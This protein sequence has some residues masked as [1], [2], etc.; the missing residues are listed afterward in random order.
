MGFIAMKALA[1]GLIHNMAAAYAYQHQFNNVVPIWGLQR[2]R[3]LDE[4]LDCRQRN[5]LLT[6][7]DVCLAIEKDRAELTGEFCR[8]CG[9][10]MPCPAEI[11]I[12]SCARIS[13]MIRRAPEAPWLSEEYQQKMKKIE[14]CIGCG[15][16]REKCPYGLDTPELLKRNLKDYMEI[17]SK[18]Q[19]A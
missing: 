17:L 13:L 19:G 6:D 5:P 16:C 7:E 15:R 8:G 9:Y 14:A 10:C 12:N 1:G 18:R 2:E 4:L 11:E 3:E